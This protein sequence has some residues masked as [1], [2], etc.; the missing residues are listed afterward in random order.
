M[1][2]QLS[3]LVAIFSMTAVGC[4]KD[5]KNAK[6][7]PAPE[8]VAVT[9]GD[10]A[11]SQSNNNAAAKK[12]E[13]KGNPSDAKSVTK[14]NAP[15][16]AHAGVWLLGPCTLLGPYVSVASVWT[17]AATVGGYTSQVKYR[18]NKISTVVEWHVP[19]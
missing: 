2:W 3:L 7:P 15:V 8:K 4:E 16:T 13:S 14:N 12:L 5:H 10:G 11:V 19:L 9:S 17:R 18:R 1:K 6:Q